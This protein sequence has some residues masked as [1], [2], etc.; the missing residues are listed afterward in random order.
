MNQPQPGKLIKHALFMLSE[1]PIGIFYFVIAVTGITLSIGLIP[2][3]IGLPLF[4]ALMGFASVIAKFEYARCHALLQEMPEPPRDRETLVVNKRF[5][6]RV[7]H[8]LTNPDG[9]KGYVLMLA[10]LPLGICAFTI[11]VVLISIS[12]GLL[13]YPIVYYI[14]LETIQVDIYEDNLLAW[15]TDLGPWESSAIYFGIGLLFTYWVGRV[16]PAISKAYLQITLQLLK[17]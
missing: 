6:G 10:K 12:V 14:L 7:I 2:I 13:A 11:T 9:W 16:L 17:L 5:W 3:F 8:A 4:I 15:V 1:L